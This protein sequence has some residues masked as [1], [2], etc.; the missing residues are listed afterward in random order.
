MAD[1]WAQDGGPAFPQHFQV[2]GL[3]GAQGLTMR[4]WFATHAMIA[5]MASELS[6]GS[7]DVAATKQ[8]VG[9]SDALANAAYRYADKML[10]ERAK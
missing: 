3:L 6:V 8:H 7:L 4:D 9:L 10:S 2:V 5:I 1:E